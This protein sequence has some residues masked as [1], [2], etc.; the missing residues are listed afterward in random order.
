MET[1]Q[2]EQSTTVKRDGAETRTETHNVTVTRDDTPRRA[3]KLRDGRRHFQDGF[4][5]DAG[6]EVMLTRDQARAF[7]DKFVPSD[8]NGDFKIG[9]YKAYRPKSMRDEA[10][11]ANESKREYGKGEKEDGTTGD[12]VPTPVIGVGTV[13]RPGG[14]LPDPSALA[15]SKQG[16]QTKEQRQIIDSGGAPPAI[17]PSS[18]PSLEEQQREATGREPK[19][20]E[21][22]PT[23]ATTGEVKK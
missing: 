10:Q 3:Y 19:K 13:G 17:L 6:D 12:P 21:K 8:E 4:A 5:V 15:P 18:V 14:P 22:K 23:A 16:Q 7:A 11:A 2:Q 1:R 20:D 9:E